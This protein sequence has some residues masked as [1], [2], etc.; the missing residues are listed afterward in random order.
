MRCFNLTS[1]G[2]PWCF[3]CFLWELRSAIACAELL[4]DL[5]RQWAAARV[6]VRDVSVIGA[7]G[8]AG[9][10]DLREALVEIPVLPAEFN[11]IPVVQGLVR[12]ASGGRS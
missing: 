2:G 7:T 1:L 6:D 10:V 9:N 8:A 4:S 12:Y 11:G 3:S 5:L